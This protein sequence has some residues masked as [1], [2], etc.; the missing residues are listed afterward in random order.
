MSTPGAL[1]LTTLGNAV[2]DALAVPA[3]KAKAKAKSKAKAKAKAMAAQPQTVKEKRDAARFL[4]CCIHSGL[5]RFLV[6]AFFHG[7]VWFYLKRFYHKLR[8]R[9]EEG[10]FQCV[11]PV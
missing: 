5:S 11:H 6:V 8:Q 7:S 1:S 3:A 9:A 10:T 2:Q 4:V